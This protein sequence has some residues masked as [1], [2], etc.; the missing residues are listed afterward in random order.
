MGDVATGPYH[1]AAQGR[2]TREQGP[3]CGSSR[4]VQGRGRS[5]LAF[6]FGTYLGGDP[7]SWESCELPR[8]GKQHEKTSTLRWSG[9]VSPTRGHTHPHTQPLLLRRFLAPHVSATLGPAPLLPR[10]PAVTRTW[11]SGG[12]AGSAGGPASPR[13]GRGKEEEI[14]VQRGHCKGGQVRYGVGSLRLPLCFVLKSTGTLEGKD[15]PP[16]G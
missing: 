16:Q 14:G 13:W 3:G 10:A 1:R 5:L 8:P 12:G 9:L 4:V 15:A 6:A 2:G 7:G 11:R